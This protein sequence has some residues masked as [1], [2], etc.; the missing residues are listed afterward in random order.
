MNYPDLP[1]VYLNPWFKGGC[2]VQDI[3]FT[4]DQEL[5]P[6]AAVK[7]RIQV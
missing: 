4:T 1:S 2:M 6:G 3:A 5:V 7:P